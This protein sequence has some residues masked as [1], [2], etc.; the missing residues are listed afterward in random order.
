MLHQFKWSFFLLLYIDRER[1]V[2]TDLMLSRVYSS[3]FIDVHWILNEYHHQQN[4][5]S[6]AG[7]E[8]KLWFLF[9]RF[10]WLVFKR[11]GII[12]HAIFQNIQWGA[13]N[14]WIENNVVV[15]SITVW[16]TYV[17]GWNMSS[18]TFFTFLKNFPLFWSFPEV[19]VSWW[20]GDRL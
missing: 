19:D 9:W 6:A 12:D 15:L 7:A 4:M 16:Q 17:K 8:R 20:I 5:D 11:I 10:S 2:T 14:R 13:L 1:V 18:V 3:S